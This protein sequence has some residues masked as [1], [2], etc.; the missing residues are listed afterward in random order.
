MVDHLFLH[1]TRRMHIQVGWNFKEVA[2]E[3]NALVGSI[4]GAGRCP[5]PLVGLTLYI[6]RYTVDRYS[7]VSRCSTSSLSQTAS[8]NMFQSILRYFLR[9]AIWISIVPLSWFSWGKGKCLCRPNL[10]YIYGI[11]AC[12]Y[13]TWIQMNTSDTSGSISVF[14]IVRRSRLRNMLALE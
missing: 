2:S 4:P 1:T 13:S 3:H 8:F 9:R 11:T 12:T 14:L 5:A 6:R 10:Y 7:V